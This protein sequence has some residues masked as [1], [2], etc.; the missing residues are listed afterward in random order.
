M[1]T[2]HIAFYQFCSAVRRKGALALCLALCMLG[3][4]LS[5]S[6]QKHRPT[7]I[8]FDVQGAGP[9]TTP[10]MVN[11]RGEITG[12]YMDANNVHQGFLRTP[13][14]RITKF[15]V[16]GAGTGD[17]QGTLP[18]VINQEGAIAG[19]YID[20]NDVFRGFLRDPHGR[21]TTFDAPDAGNTGNY[22]YCGG[23]G[24]TSEGIN[25]AGAIAG[26][27]IDK[28]WVGH[29]YVRDPDGKITP[30]DPRGSVYTSM[31][32]WIAFVHCINPAGAI[33]GWYVDA[34]NVIHGF[35]RD[36][37][38][39]ITTFEAPG[40]GTTGDHGTWP[41]SINPEGTI[42]GAVCDDE[43]VCQSFLRDPHGG[44]TAFNIPGVAIQYYTTAVD[45]NLAGVILGFYFDENGV[46]GFLRTPDGRITTFD[47]PGS[48]GTLPTSINAA[49]EITGWY[50]D[51]NGVNHAFLRI[52]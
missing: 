30:F 3:L 22:P 7:Y 51:A 1:M 31:N 21:F 18:T 46:H 37:H 13:D 11:D 28:D 12:W 23:Q 44:M 26:Y 27:Y 47:V 5:A 40:A 34:S 16:P 35:L 39:K 36:P 9:T 17:C 33:T 24:T 19:H 32:A 38:G 4:G 10:W 6:A 2:N 20:T 8:T 29:G 43:G 45:I 42:V 25:P 15:H 50:T 14:G 49:G 48:Q 52:P 41:N